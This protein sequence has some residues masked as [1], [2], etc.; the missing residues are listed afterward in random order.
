MQ[1]LDSCDVLEQG[2]V[3][4]GSEV[5]QG[6]RNQLRRINTLKQE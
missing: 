4:T 5:G 3:V 1:K 6:E 2:M